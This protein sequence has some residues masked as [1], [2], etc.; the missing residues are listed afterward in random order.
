MAVDQGHIAESIAKLSEAVL[1]PIDDSVI[2]AQRQTYADS[3]EVE[4]P[5]NDAFHRRLDRYLDLGRPKRLEHC[6]ENV[7][8]HCDLTLQNLSR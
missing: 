4:E 3:F 6:G 8:A 7:Q 5:V 2:V 1:E